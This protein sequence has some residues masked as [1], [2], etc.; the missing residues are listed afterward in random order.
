M[1]E[2][3]ITYMLFK[4]TTAINNWL[5]FL[6]LSLSFSATTTTTTNQQVG[7]SLFRLMLFAAS[8]SS[9]TFNEKILLLSRKICVIFMQNH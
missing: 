3:R 7:E 4:N 2:R 9:R 5:A 8:N 6:T 1:S